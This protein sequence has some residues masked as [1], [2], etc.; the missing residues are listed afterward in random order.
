MKLLKT[1]WCK[2]HQD[3]HSKKKKENESPATSIC[4]AIPAWSV[5]TAVVDRETGQL[6]SFSSLKCPKTPGSQRVRSP[7]IRWNRVRTSITGHLFS[8]K[9]KWIAM[10]Y[11]QIGLPTSS[12][13]S[14][15]LVYWTAEARTPS[16]LTNMAWPQN[17][18]RFT[19]KRMLT[20]T[21]PHMNMKA[22]RTHPWI[23]AP[24]PCEAC[25]LGSAVTSNLFKSGVD[26][27][28]NCQFIDSEPPSHIWRWHRHHVGLSLIRLWRDLQNFICTKC[29]NTGP[30]CK[31]NASPTLPIENDV[32]N[33]TLL[34]FP[35][36][37]PSGTF[38][39]T[40]G[41]KKPA[42]SHQP[43]QTV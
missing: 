30:K 42:S 4:V 26:S 39:A 20:W 2:W 40:S 11:S 15:W 7:R 23:L 5:P 3:G 24:G 37:T 16:K 17:V 35:I 34:W 18:F 31:V 8:G 27:C 32:E 10:V 38:S 6:W 22:N 41:R 21:Y 12:S 28:H 36:S 33:V 13:H 25:K 14:P 43:G 19:F 9:E 1:M 29:H